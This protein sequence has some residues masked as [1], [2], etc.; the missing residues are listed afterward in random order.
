MIKNNSLKRKVE[1]V[2]VFRFI[3]CVF[4]AANNFNNIMLILST[5]KTERCD[6]ILFN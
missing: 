3:N 1:I 5:I 2:S 6:Q 4:I